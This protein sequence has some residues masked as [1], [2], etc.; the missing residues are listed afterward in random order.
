MILR[1]L[2]VWLVFYTLSSLILSNLKH[3]LL[4]RLR[5]T[6][7]ANVLI[8]IEGYD[9]INASI[10][11]TLIVTCNAVAFLSFLSILYLQQ[12]TA[13]YSYNASI[14][15][16]RVNKRFFRHALPCV[17]Y[18]ATKKPG[19]IKARFVALLFLMGQRTC[20]FAPCTLNYYGNSVLS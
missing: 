20:Y 4:N 16:A 7:A 5:S 11:F 14:D 17:T 19:N 2:C 13:Y 3:E 1:R 18:F 15:N 6:M 10:S 12:P 9:V 8:V